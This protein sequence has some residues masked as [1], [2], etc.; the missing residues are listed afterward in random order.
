[1]AVT[2]DKLLLFNSHDCSNELSDEELME[3]SDAADL[4]EYEL[5]DCVLGSNL[6]MTSVNFIVNG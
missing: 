5:G 3:I 1:M 4:V 2:H 6:P